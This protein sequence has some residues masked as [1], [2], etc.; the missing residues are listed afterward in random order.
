[1]KKNVLIYFTG[2][3]WCSGCKLLKRDL[4]ETDTFSELTNNY[5]L[6]YVNVPFKEDVISEKQLKYNKKL[7]A[8]YNPKNIFPLIKVFNYKGKE[9][10]KISGYTG[11]AGSLE[12]YIKFLEKYK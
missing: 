2:S 10:D 5:T 9:I 11:I 12:Y 3:D 6:L 7:R 8:K 1:M 4:F